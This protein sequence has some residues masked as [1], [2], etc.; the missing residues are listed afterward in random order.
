MY[1]KK[2]QYYITVIFNDFHPKQI[3]QRRNKIYR[4]RVFFVYMNK[5]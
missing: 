1:Y 3:I 2:F 5:L 4:Q